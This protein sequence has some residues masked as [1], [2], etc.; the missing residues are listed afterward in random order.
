MPDYQCAIC[1]AKR[2]P[3]T[4]GAPP[5]EWWQCDRSEACVCQDCAV[6]LIIEYGT[7]HGREK[8]PR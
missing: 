8:E 4:D 5:R 2:A 7:R 1:G 3:M 6:K